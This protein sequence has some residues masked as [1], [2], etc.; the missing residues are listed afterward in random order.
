M[1]SD[2]A[3]LIEVQG[4]VD[5]VRAH[6]VP[7]ILVG[8]EPGLRRELDKVGAAGE[9][10]IEVR[11]A[12]EVITMHDAPSMAVKQKKRSSMRVCF[13]L[14]KAGDAEAVVSAGNSG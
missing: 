13:D 12:P 6:G 11:H 1:G 8:D 10:A 4:V 14:V 5:A 7:V 3:P 2:G 9:S